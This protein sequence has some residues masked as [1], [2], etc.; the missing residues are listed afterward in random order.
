LLDE[1]VLHDAIFPDSVLQ[2][3]GGPRHG[4]AA[5][6]RRVGADRRALTSSALKPQGMAVRELA[7][8]AGR[9][10]RGGLDF[11][12]DDHGLADQVYGPF[13]DRVAAV[14]AAVRDARAGDGGRTV[15]LPSLSGDLDQLRRQIALARAEGIDAVLIA[16]MIVGLPAF[17]VIRRENPDIAVMAHP[18]L[19]GAARIAP[20]FLLGKFFRLLGA[21][22]TVFPNYGG[23][24]G[25]SPETCRALARA[26]LEPWNGFP[27]TV[28]VPA[29]G[30]TMDRV[31]EML[32]F[33]GNDVMLLIGGNLLAAGAQITD[34][35]AAF[36]A[37]VKQRSE[38]R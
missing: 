6:R 37:T 3:F 17:H 14:A 13:A 32:S 31:A 18:A 23:R 20:P 30:M 10:A 35:A 5:L 33:Y 2:A 29:G 7:Q 19:A 25:Y 9:L 21:D 24:F 11:I 22:A 16:P 4:L 38:G 28:P 12:K 34:A 26:A 27:A 8:L 1:V 15:Y 36:V